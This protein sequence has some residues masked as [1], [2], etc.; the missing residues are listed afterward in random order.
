MIQVIP[1][2]LISS[3]PMFRAEVAMT[4]SSTNGEKLL[5]SSLW[6]S[7]CDQPSHPEYSWY[8]NVTSSARKAIRTRRRRYRSLR[9]DF[10]G[11]PPV[12]RAA[13]YRVPEAPLLRAQRYLRQFSMTRKPNYPYLLTMTGFLS[14]RHRSTAVKRHREVMCCAA[15]EEVAV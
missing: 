15:G 1:N 12:P 14:R 6:S 2:S 7:S 11:A 8:Y 13:Y 5:G 4:A 9:A 3:A 10:P